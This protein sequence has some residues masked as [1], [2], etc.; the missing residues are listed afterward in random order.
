MSNRFC[1]R[2]V[3]LPLDRTYIMG[4]LNVTPDSFSDGGVFL[5]P[6]KAIAHALEME[7]QGADI[8]DIGGQST[9]PGHQKI[10]PQEEILRLKPVFEALRGQLSIPLSVDTYYPEV[11]ECALALGAAIVNDVGSV[12][13]SEMASVVKRYRAGWIITDTAGDDGGGIIKSVQKRLAALAV[14]AR[15]LGV[16]EECLCIDPGFGFGKDAEENIDLLLGLSQINPDGYALLAGA[17]RKRFVGYLTGVED[18]AGRDP[19]TAAV[20][21]I[22][23]QNGAHIIRTHN[24]AYGVQSAKVTDT[25]LRHGGLSGSVA[26]C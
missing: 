6:S 26:D 23:I 10:S 19:G 2:D 15:R 14:E 24:V 20:H 21:N 4:I 5:E 8:I 11:A 7:R 3:C 17:S 9:R 12:V 13:S 18:P 22:A 25:L 1:C 16:E